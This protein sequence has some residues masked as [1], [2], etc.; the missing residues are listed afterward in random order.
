MA[1]V[2]KLPLADRERIVQALARLASTYAAGATYY[3]RDLIARVDLPG[4]WAMS[5]ADIWTGDALADA[6]K[7]VL[8]AIAKDVNPNDR[9]YTT[10][11]SLLS[12]VMEDQGLEQRSSIVALI[13]AYGLYCD[14]SLLTRLA[15]RYQVP[16]SALASTA[17]GQACP[18][19]PFD[20]REWPNEAE[21]QR[22]FRREP[23][24][25]DVGFLTEA[26]ERAASICR[27]EMIG[28]EP[29]GTGFLVGPQAMLTNYHVV[30]SAQGKDLEEKAGNLLLRFRF[31][32]AVAGRES[33]GQTYRPDPSRPLLRFSPVEA[34]DYALIQI[35]QNIT[36]AADLL[37]VVY[38]DHLRLRKGMGLNILGHPQGG[39]MKLSASGNGI[40][41]VYT[42]A[43]LV[44]Y[45]TRALNGS[46]GSPCGARIHDRGGDLLLLAAAWDCHAAIWYSCVSPPR[47]CLRRIRRSARLISGGRVPAWAGASCPRARC[48]RAAL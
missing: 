47:T 24:F 21:L 32:T 36:S 16:V 3:Y 46:S 26:I 34:L 45:A 10:L 12:T 38:A 19:P 42:D 6:R 44:Q 7:L 37:P 2:P 14:D 30:E 9:R 27:V 35:E 18:S 31:V 40:V 22:L 23:E 39:P 48:G 5:V 4:N 20:L 25:L 29:I 43:G 15:V 41:G 8:W 1:P 33:E 11:G 13:C 28:G 17:T